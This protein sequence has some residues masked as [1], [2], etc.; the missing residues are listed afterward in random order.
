MSDGSE[1]SPIRKWPEG[2]D[3]EPEQRVELACSACGIDWHVHERMRGF[4]LRCE[5]GAWIDVPEPEGDTL[6]LAPPEELP[7]AVRAPLPAELE[8]YQDDR[9]MVELPGDDGDVFY[10]EI[11]V[12]AQMAPGT[13]RRASASN[14]RRWTNR[15]LVE[16][17]LLMLALL[18]PQLLATWL[19]E[20]TEEQLLMP[21]A[22]LLSGVL[23]ALVIAWTGPYG[24]IGL[25]PASIEYWLE[26]VAAAAAMVLLALG[27][28]YVLEALVPDLTDDWLKSLVQG[29]GLPAALLVVA[30][31]PAVLEEIIFR[32][33]LHGRFMALFG[34][35]LGL[36]V[37]AVTF[38]LAHGASPATP[39]HL[40]IGIYL[41]LLRERADSL[42]PCMLMH[43]L[44]N[45]T[46]VVL[47]FNDWV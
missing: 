16:F 25:R 20:G 33:M 46:L 39:I 6:A 15:T 8:A 45:G 11:P 37:T 24:R 35:G 13:L 22:S 47:A 18:G 4:R 41:G 28:I 42:L 17:V 10:A 36:F 7:A 19:A 2:R 5:C 44:Y 30:V 9:G 34:R 38:A 32:G 14:Q 27:Y 12:D 43:F 40:A 21:F 31:S 29:L 3:L 1:G 26:A 23:V